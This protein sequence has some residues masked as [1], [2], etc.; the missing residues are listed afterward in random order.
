MIAENSSNWR[1]D[2][3]EAMGPDESG[4]HPF[5]D[6]MPFVNQKQ[7]EAKKQEKGMESLEGGK[8]SKMAESMT[9]KQ[10]M[11]FMK[12]NPLPP[13]PKGGYD[14]A[15]IRGRQMAKAPKSKD[16][17]S[18]SQRMADAYASPRKGPGGAVRAD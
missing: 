13:V 2:L 10:Q 9:V 12:K 8:Q 1:R 6:V 4:N 7:K 18:P 11:E 5:V 17:K 3:N 14:H 16:S 15:A